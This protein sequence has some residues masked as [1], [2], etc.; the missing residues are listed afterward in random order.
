VLAKEKY[1]IRGRDLAEIHANFIPFTAQSRMSGRGGRQFLDVRKG[2][3]DSILSFLNA[4]PAVVGSNARVLQPAVSADVAREAAGD[5]PTRSP[6][7]AGRPRG[8]EG[9]APSRRDPS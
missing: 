9:R 5:S 6:D 3:V 2:A 4:P 1:G 7:Q 8:R